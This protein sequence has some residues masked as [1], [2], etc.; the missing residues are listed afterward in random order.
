MEL[1][2]VP[3]SRPDLT[4]YELRTEPA[5]L[6]EAFSDGKRYLRIPAGCRELLLHCRYRVHGFDESSPDLPSPGRVFPG[7]SSLSIL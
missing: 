7:A 3:A 5:G 6:Q 2:E 1:I 4:V